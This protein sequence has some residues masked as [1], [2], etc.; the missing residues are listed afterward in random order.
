LL[1]TASLSLVITATAADEADNIP[2]I[3]FDFE[4]G[5]H[6]NGSLE[7]SGFIE[8]EVKPTKVFWR[9]DPT[10]N[11]LWGNINSSLEVIESS[12]SR[13]SWAWSITFD[14]VDVDTFSPCTCYISITV[15]TETGESW[16]AK[17]VV[18]LG[19]TSR[20][21]IIV[22]SP[23]SGDW[24]HESLLVEGWSEY[25]MTWTM[26]ELRFFA[27]SASS[28]VD[29]CSS[30]ADSD[31]SAHLAV[32]TPDGKFSELLDI[33][34][35]SD[36]WHSLYAENYDPS[37]VTYSQECIP[38][39]INNLAPSVFIEGPEYSLEGTS[40]LIFDASSS[41]DLVWGREDMH[42]MWVLRKPSHSGQTPLE[43]VMGDD[44]GTMS[45]P[46]DNSGDYSLT[47]AVTDAGGV[48]STMVK[49]FT[50]QNVLPEAIASLDGSPIEDGARIKLS[51]GS[52]WVLDA[53][54]SIDSAND[55]AGL[56]CVWKIDYTPVYEGCERT[57]SWKSDINDP[58]I[59]T[60]DVIDDDD[61]YST[62]SVQLVHPDAS[63]PMPYS[64]IV[65]VISALFMLSAVLLRFRSSDDSSSIPK[66]K[67]DDEN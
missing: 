56:R 25:P 28:S 14:E 61:D 43:I 11:S 59:L 34:G 32:I 29:A 65:L 67:S 24:V 51:P 44:K 39:R 18:F 9:L 40:D 42:F 55:Q 2:L 33:S 38:L 16:E 31:M 36:G 3:G 20:S 27:K 58:I 49:E 17:R 4:N 15:E 47:L 45:I 53:S 26:P 5:H 8:D 57:L 7:L 62:I 21:A 64:L 13:T 46:T 37:G 66:W 1:I 63:E 30:E 50:I 19:D 54:A 12:G 41:D 52:E 35:L 6:S 23:E 48:T 22:D 60:L 10:E